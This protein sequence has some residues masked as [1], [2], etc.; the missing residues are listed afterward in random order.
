MA[1]GTTLGEKFE[2]GSAFVSYV[3]TSLGLAVVDAKAI[4]FYN[5]N[6]DMKFTYTGLLKALKVAMA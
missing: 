6:Q 2:T 3:E 5:A 4:N 1:T